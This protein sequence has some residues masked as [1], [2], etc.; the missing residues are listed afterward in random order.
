MAN[1][2][3][4]TNEQMAGPDRDRRSGLDEEN[5]RGGTADDVRGIADEEDDEFEDADDL[6]EDED[7]DESL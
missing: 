2:R 7:S 4:R 1:D 3:N 6:D 5:M